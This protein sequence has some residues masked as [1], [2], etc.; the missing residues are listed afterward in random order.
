MRAVSDPARGP[1]PSSRCPSVRR[2]LSQFLPRGRSAR[3]IPWRARLCTAPGPLAGA[4]GGIHSPSSGAPGAALPR[5]LARQHRLRVPSLQHPRPPA[6][7]PSSRCPSVRRALSQFLPRGRSARYIPWRAR[8]CTAPG[9][10]TGAAGGIHS[11][12]SGAPGPAASRHAPGPVTPSAQ[13]SAAR[14]ASGR[15]RAARA[16]LTQRR[17]RARRVARASPHTLR[18]GGTSGDASSASGAV[19]ARCRAALPRRLAGQHRLRVPSLQHRAAAAPPFAGRCRSS[20]RAAGR[21]GTFHRARAACGAREPPH[22]APRRCQRRRLKRQRCRGRA[23][24]R[25]CYASRI[26]SS[27]TATAMRAVSDPARR[28]HTHHMHILIELAF[29]RPLPDPVTA[30]SPFTTTL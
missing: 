18:L 15:P 20:C 19:A 24:A 22:P 30:N 8:L 4:A 2:A 13:P 26:S 1:A 23:S 3:Y 11:P 25:V 6:L 27:A 21:R 14:P 16:P 7:P 10:L 29:S 9:P 17:A 28:V 5:R 12:S